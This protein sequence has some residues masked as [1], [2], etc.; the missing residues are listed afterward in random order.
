MSLEEKL[1]H[2]LD[3]NLRHR[4]EVIEECGNAIDFMRDYSYSH[5]IRNELATALNIYEKRNDIKPSDFDGMEILHTK[6]QITAYEERH[7][8]KGF[9]FDVGIPKEKF[10][11]L[12]PKV[13]GKEWYGGLYFS[14]IKFKGFY[15]IHLDFG[16]FALS[17]EQKQ[18]SFEHESLHCDRKFYTSDY[19]DRFIPNYDDDYP[20]VKWRALAELSFAEEMFCFMAEGYEQEYVAKTISTKY[21]ESNLDFISGIFRGITDE[22]K[23]EKRKQFEQILMPVKTR[24]PF[25][26]KYAYLLKENLPFNALTPLFFLNRY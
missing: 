17:L 11:A 6:E 18:G 1:M 25:A 8:I 22:Q 15:H 5:D 26:V 4:E 3:V 14:P 16:K 13:G 7:G 24:I 9:L 12:M 2:C 20:D 23:A 10:K 21:F 19:L